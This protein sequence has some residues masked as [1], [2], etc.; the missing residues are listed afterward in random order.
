MKKLYNLLFLLTITTSL[1]FAQEPAVFTVEVPA[2][3]Q[4]VRMTGNFWGWNPVGGPIAT[5]NGLDNTWT[6]T[7]FTN[8]GETQSDFEYLWVITDADNSSNP[9]QENL[10]SS[11]AAGDCLDRI[12]AGEFN[13]DYANYANRKFIAAGSDDIKSDVY[14]SCYLAKDALE[15]KGILDFTVPS[16]GSDGK[17]IHL[18]ANDNIADLSV[19]GIG[20]ANNGGGTDGIEYQFPQQSVSAGQHIFLPRSQSAMTTYFVNLNQFDVIIEAGVASQNGD[21]AIELFNN[22][23]SDGAGGYTGSVIETFGNLDCAPT[24]STPCNDYQFYSD[25]WAYKQLGV[26]GFG[27]VDCTD[28]TTT[29]QGS[30]CVYP[31]ADTSLSTTNFSNNQFSIYPNPVNSGF[32]N[33]KSR[34]A[35]E[36]HITLYDVMGRE[37]LN[38][39]LQSNTL[40]VSSVNNGL[41]LL[42]VSVN[43]FSSIFKLVIN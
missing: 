22:V 29:T 20:V 17:A 21:D 31:F 13:T 5:S 32:V 23:V 15:L 26:W 12:N 10:I 25:T 34:I 42:N 43:E 16:G 30:T 3:T 38:T 33:I 7:L 27:T 11:A 2:G 18:Y 14:G 37:V 41:Y 1:A 24:A 9:Q 6:V 4:S 40:D 19:Y 39:K 35:G 28:N 36:K 8:G